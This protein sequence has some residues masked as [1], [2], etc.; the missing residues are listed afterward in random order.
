MHAF[1]LRRTMSVVNG[2]GHRDRPGQCFG[3][4]R[5]AAPAFRQLLSWRQ[6]SRSSASASARAKTK[7]V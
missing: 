2:W 4:R 1:I 7:T 5:T 3:W 6:K